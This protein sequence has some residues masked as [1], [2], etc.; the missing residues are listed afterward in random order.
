VGTAPALVK[1]S[2][3]LIENVRVHDLEKKTVLSVERRTVIPFPES[4]TESFRS[5]SLQNQTLPYFVLVI[6]QYFVLEIIMYS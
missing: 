5:I 3:L 4:R 2:P 1:L 6:R